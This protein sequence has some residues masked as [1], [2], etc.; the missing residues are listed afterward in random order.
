[1]KLIVSALVSV[2]AMLVAVTVAIGDEAPGKPIRHLVFTVHVGTDTKQDL[3][4]YYGHMTSG[5][6]STAANGTITVDVIGLA[7]DNA[8][9]VRVSENSD[10]RKAA[11][12]TVEVLADGR[13][14]VD[15][16]STGALNEEEQALV[17][18]LARSLVADH[19][20]TPGNFWHVT[21]NGKGGNDDAVYRVTSL[22]G[23][24]Q[25][26]LD[27]ERQITVNGAQ[28]MDITITGKMLYDYQRSVPL[29]AALNQH[30]VIK[31]VEAQNTSDLSF[32]YNLSQDSRASAVSAP[33]AA[34]AAMPSGS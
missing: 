17:G 20:L 34:P 2:L 29:S 3:T 24:G 31:T 23:E 9:I 1:M 13:V 4:N 15:P 28:P 7:A 19:E 27:I 6:N 32:E 8:L 12:A 26:N 5:K 11:P 18:L 14:A 10:T 25:V 21:T 33:T 16:K 22:G 30:V